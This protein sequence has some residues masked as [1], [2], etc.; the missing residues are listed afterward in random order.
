MCVM[1]H[2]RVLKAPNLQVTDWVYDGKLPPPMCVNSRLW[3]F[4]DATTHTNTEHVPT[5]EPDGG[6]GGR[7]FL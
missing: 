2:P 5:S 3:W 4:R 7:N 6:G 1:S